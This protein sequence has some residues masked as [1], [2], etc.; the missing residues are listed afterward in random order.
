LKPGGTF[1]FEMGGQGNVVEMEGALLEAVGKRVGSEK[2]REVDPWFF[3]GE[4]WMMRMLEKHG[5]VVEKMELEA[6]PTKV[7]EGEGGG[8]DGW[9]KLM[10]KRFF[11]VV[12]EEGSADREECVREVVERLEREC[13]GEDSGHVIGYVRLRTLASK[14]K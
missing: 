14:P 3:P 7:E 11:D 10:G 6:R 9:I 8:I 4:E 1:V 5:F 12:G 13:K 2:A